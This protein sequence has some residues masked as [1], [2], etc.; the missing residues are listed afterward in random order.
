MDADTLRALEES[1]THWEKNVVASSPYEVTLGGASCA[2]CH[3]FVYN[4]TESIPACSGCPVYEHTGF[5][6]CR[7]SPYL[8]VFRAYQNW[9]YSETEEEHNILRTEYQAAAQ[10]ELDFLRSLRPTTTPVSKD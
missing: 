9:L 8:D 6:S 3:K 1:I 4:V 10:A 7:N 2:L 5:S